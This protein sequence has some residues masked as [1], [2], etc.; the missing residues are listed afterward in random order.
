MVFIDENKAQLMYVYGICK[1]KYIIHKLKN[2]YTI[3]KRQYL[4][5]SSTKI[6]ISVLKIK[7][8]NI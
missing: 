7:N 3:R 2:I 1:H 8:T 5:Y 6:K 4:I